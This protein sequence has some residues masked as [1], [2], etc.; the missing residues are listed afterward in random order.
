MESNGNSG[1]D[2]WYKV[3]VIEMQHVFVKSEMFIYML[4]NNGSLVEYRGLLGF[5]LSLAFSLSLCS[6]R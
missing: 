6:D 1:L 4:V 2:D 3:W 5:S